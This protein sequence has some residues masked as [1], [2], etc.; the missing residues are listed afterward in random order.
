MKGSDMSVASVTMIDYMSEEVADEIE[1][2][3]REICAQILTEGDALILV[4]NRT[5]SG[6][7]IAI[8]KTEE[9]AEERL[10]TRAKMLEQ[11]LFSI[12]DVFYLNGPLCLRYVNGLLLENKAT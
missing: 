2:A 6:L 1:A 11:C 4:C 9:L 5:T 7:S 10:P 12:Q 3:Y 8:N